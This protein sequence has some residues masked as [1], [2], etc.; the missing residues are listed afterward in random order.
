ML[1][2]SLVPLNSS[3]IEGIRT[4]QNTSLGVLATRLAEHHSDLSADMQKIKDQIKDSNNTQMRIESCL[5]GEVPMHM[6]RALPMVRGCESDL[7]LGQ[8]STD[9][10]LNQRTA[11]MIQQPLIEV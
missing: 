11:D 2:E 5:R 1:H 4:V 10:N 3:L 9:R 7:S 8:E 6:A